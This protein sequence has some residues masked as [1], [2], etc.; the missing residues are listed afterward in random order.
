M[1]T[2]TKSSKVET[3]LSD[4]VNRLAESE[5]LL[6][7]R[8]SR[9]LQ[10]QGLDIISLTLGEP[11]FNTPDYVKE[12]AKKAIDEN[13]TRYT[14]V[15]GYNEL[16]V[17]IANK[18]KRENNL[19]Y[20]PLQI[21]VSAGA[22]HSIANA[23]MALVN[24]GEEV[25]IP[26]PYWVSY[27]ELVRLAQGNCVCP[28]ATIENDFKITAKQLEASITDKTKL[29]IFSS[30]CNPSGSVYSKEELRS[31]ANVIA[32][33]DDLY[34]ISDEIYEHINFVGKHESIAQF[35]FI[36]D[37]VILIN[38]VSKAYAMTGWRIGYMAA[39]DWIIKAC[40]KLQG[41]MT[42]G[43][44]SIAQK[45]AEAALNGDI[46]FVE[47]MVATFKERRDLVFNLMNKIPGIKINKPDGAFYV[48]PDVSYYFGKTDGQTYISNSSDLSMYL[49]NKALVSMVPG[50]A[51]GS[52]ECLR[53]SYATSN[54]KLIEAIKRI[55]KALSEL[56]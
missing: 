53:L 28:V 50:D 56:K 49:L 21:L 4:R 17:A 43:V 13:Y 8:K 10:A 11:D 55:E 41:Q 18:L 45:A 2:M 48:F 3:N 38:G 26:S 5:T 39:P 31:L 30:P 47:E 14:P 40:D 25:I 42:S 51:F 15:C 52:P 29:I 16:K 54:D 33:H 46:K 23:V 27:K 7:A 22:K 36:K 44:C 35:E 32:S 20:N 24:H 9:E 12:A 37:R 1:D 6:M 19:D 34:V